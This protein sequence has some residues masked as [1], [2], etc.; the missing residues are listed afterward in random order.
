[1]LERDQYR[2]AFLRALAQ[3]DWQNVV[4]NAT[5][6]LKIDDTDPMLW[7]NRGLAL[8]KLGFPFDAILN[9]DR[10]LPLAKSED[11]Q[12]A[13]YTN[14]GAAY[15]DIGNADRALESLEKAIAIRPVAQAFMTMGNIYRQQGDLEKGILAYRDSIKA[16]PD[17]VDG[18]M[19]LGMALLKTGKLNEGWRE[20][21]WRWKSDQLPLRKL[22]CPQWKGENLTNKTIL[23]YGEQGLGDI[24]QFA[25]YARILGNQYPRAK[26]IVEG[27]HPLKR[28][29]ETIPEVYA[30]INSGDKLPEL[31]YAVPMITLAGILT[32]SVN[33]I[34]AENREYYLRPADVEA[35][36]E[37]LAPL[38]SMN[39]S[40]L[41]VGICWAGMSRDLHPSAAA[42]DAIRSTSLATFA[43][44]AKIENILWVSLQKGK[45]AEQIKQPPAG[46]IIGDFT[47][48]MYDFYE[49]CC[50][51]ANCDL[52]ISVD[53]AVVHA[54]ASV[55]VPTWLLSRWDGCWRW[56]GDREDSPW[57]PSLR[58]FVQPAPHDWDGM[59]KKVATELAKLAEDKNQPE[60][61]LTLAN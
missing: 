18:H 39:R 21:E 26:I 8:Q 55:G 16:D 52:V 48:E 9:Y 25:R 31:D 41:K 30:V 61:N 24:I 36:S 59:M 29:L 56:F 13:N 14:K 11:L 50:A 43:P 45:P 40:A 17:Y 53:T 2:E 1:M 22:R 12:I 20:Y 38:F 19:M 47:D 42:V 60:L 34:F 37:K 3:H 6:L 7:G 27:R 35:W 23:I 28:L 4:L 15:W 33:E 10:A 54:A 58:Q 44:L 51:A 49:T 57:Y 32:W 46:M 5:S